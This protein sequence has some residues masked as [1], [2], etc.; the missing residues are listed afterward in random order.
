[1]KSIGIEGSKVPITFKE[2]AKNTL[3]RYRTVINEYNK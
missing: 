1:M 2:M 3:E